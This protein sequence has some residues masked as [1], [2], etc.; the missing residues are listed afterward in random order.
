MHHFVGSGMDCNY[1]DSI[2][3]TSVYKGSFMLI[4]YEQPLT[5]TFI[6]T[7]SDMY[8]QWI[9]IMMLLLLYLRFI[10]IYT[11]IYLSFR[12]R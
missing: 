3:N 1:C 9:I 6:I 11:A 7:R 8:K 10:I 2:K 12:A 5:F 4:L